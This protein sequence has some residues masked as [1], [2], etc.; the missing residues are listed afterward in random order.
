MTQNNEKIS[1]IWHEASFGIVHEIGI[2][3]H[4]FSGGYDCSFKYQC[5]LEAVCGFLMSLVFEKTGGTVQQDGLNS[6][7]IKQQQQSSELM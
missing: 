3:S 7:F 2:V 1:H 5:Y 6:A 4:I